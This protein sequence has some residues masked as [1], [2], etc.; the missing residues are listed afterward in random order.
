MLYYGVFGIFSGPAARPAS[1]ARNGRGAVPSEGLHRADLRAHRVFHEEDHMNGIPVTVAIS[2]FAL[3]PALADDKPSEQAAKK[4]SEAIVALGCS[5][6]EMEN[7]SEARA[8]STSMMPS[9][10]TGNSASSSTMTSS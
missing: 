3:T 6:G 8:I 10:R 1:L 5:G 2:L 7:E 9:A 4:I